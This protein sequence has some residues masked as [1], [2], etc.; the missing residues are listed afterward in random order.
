M[1]DSV[2]QQAHH[3]IPEGV[4]DKMVKDFIA[5][6]GIMTLERAEPLSHKL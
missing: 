3:I 2:P 4:F 5:P 1:S 6:Y